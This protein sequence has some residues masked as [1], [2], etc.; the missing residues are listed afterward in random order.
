MVEPGPDG[1]VCGKGVGNSMTMFR[2]VKMRAAER[3]VQV[4][5]G[6]RALLMGVSHLAFVSVGTLVISA[7]TAS[8]EQWTGAVSTDWHDA[9]NWDTG[10]P[11]GTLDVLVNNNLPNS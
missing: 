8:A 1:A 11:T 2:G 9:A 5:Y 7:T 6:A 4:R 3:Q 10:V